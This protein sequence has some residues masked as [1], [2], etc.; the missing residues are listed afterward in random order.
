MLLGKDE[1]LNGFLGKEIYFNPLSP[2]INMHILLTVVH[3]F[4]MIPLGEFV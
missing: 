4:D 3:M 2:D 1:K